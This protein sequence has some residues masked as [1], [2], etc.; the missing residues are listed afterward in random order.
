MQD[1]AFRCIVCSRAVL[2]G[3]DDDSN[4]TSG[5]SAETSNPLVRTSNLESTLR[6]ARFLFNY[7]TWQIGR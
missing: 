3:G 7:E 4:S 5:S 1:E 2:N 6:G